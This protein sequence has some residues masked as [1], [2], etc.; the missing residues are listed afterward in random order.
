MET[1]MVKLFNGEKIRTLKLKD[2]KR[3]EKLKQQV[4]DYDVSNV[5][6]F[7]NGLSNILIYKNH[8]SK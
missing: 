6:L 1:D 5:D 7:L 8:I 3:D 2:K 4:L